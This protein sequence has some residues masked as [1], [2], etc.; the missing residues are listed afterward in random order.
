MQFNWGKEAVTLISSKENNIQEVSFK[1]W[2]KGACF[3]VVQ[4][5]QIP[6]R[7]SKNVDSAPFEIQELLKEFQEVLTEPK[8]LPP[9]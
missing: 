7:N 5:Q 2:K 6:N 8:G 4:V 3:Y 1:S 9:K